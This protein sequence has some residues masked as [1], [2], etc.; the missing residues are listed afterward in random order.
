MT[1]SCWKKCVAGVQNV[2]LNAGEI[3][4]TDNCAMKFMNL[5][6]VIFIGCKNIWN[7]CTQNVPKSCILQ[8][9]P[10]HITNCSLFTGDY[11]PYNANREPGGFR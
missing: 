8:Y 11:K 2:E 10:R 6:E 9:Y 4:C 5:A 7:C 1:E 3:S